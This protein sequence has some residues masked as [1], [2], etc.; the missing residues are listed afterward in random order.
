MTLSAITLT[1]PWASLIAIGA[2]TVETRSWTTPYRG[3]IAIHASREIDYDV[4]RSSPF[5]E[6]LTAAG[7]PVTELPTRS[8]VA[9][10]DLLEIQRSDWFHG[11]VWAPFAQQQL[12][13]AFGDFSPGRFG[14]RLRNIRRLPRPIECRGALT[15]WQL[16]HDIEAQ[17]LAQLAEIY[18]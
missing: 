2:K 6:V 15:I 9:V 12:D 17:V 13:L 16:P 14:F 11:R 10:A 5:A 1:Q 18:V 4:C 3:P 7:I 8:I